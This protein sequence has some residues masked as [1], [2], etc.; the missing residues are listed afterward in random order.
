MAEQVSPR[1]ALVFGDAAQVAHV[2]DALSGQVEIVAEAIG[3]DFDVARLASVH[4]Q[5][6]LVNLDGSDWLGDAAARL[7]EAG[8]R[9]VFND[10]EI[11]HKLEGW[12][13]ARWRRHLVAKLRGST[14]FDPPRP[15]FGV[16][17]AAAGEPATPAATDAAAA[18]ASPTGAD[19]APESAA[20]GFVPVAA[21]SDVLERPLSAAEIES[22][23]ARFIAPETA[24]PRTAVAVPAAR[25]DAAAE[26]DL[27]VDTAA[28]SAMIDARLAEAEPAPAAPPA[29]WDAPE[30]VVAP[31]IESP[32]KAGAA[33][34]GE[35]A[36]PTLTD[37]VVPAA[38][39]V[40]AGDEVDVLQG[41]P[42]LGDW[43]LVDPDAPVAPVAKPQR[44]PLQAPASALDFAGLEL[45]PMETTAPIEL[46]A[47]PVERWMGAKP[48][49]SGIPA[50]G[51]APNAAPG[52]S[53]DRA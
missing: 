44:E 9:T 22:M 45:V 8:M 14:D 53:G 28:L 38:P 41:L 12:D 29:V 21:E 33:E 37:V 26:P 17:A 11:S 4:A 3:A 46:H 6:V 25:T 30:K 40:A 35:A 5:A 31:G 1:I 15:A 27:D 51:S 36:V 43:Q 48:G 7:D 34:A 16:V 20:P 42:A 32:V 49:K 18:D 50:A 39:A 23:S 2:R 47:D 19:K 52:P 10:P 13:Q 24:A